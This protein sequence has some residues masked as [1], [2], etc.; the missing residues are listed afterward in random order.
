VQDAAGQ[1]DTHLAKLRAI[2]PA[3]A[4]RQ[5]ELESL[6]LL[7][8]AGANV[9]VVQAGKLR[10]GIHSLLR[11]LDWAAISASAPA[12]RESIAEMARLLVAVG[13]EVCSVCVCVC[14]CVSRFHLPHSVPH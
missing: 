6:E 10:D 13:G 1:G 5:D 12:E 7:A 11:S 3:S 14:V 8:A 9:E 2:K 4:W